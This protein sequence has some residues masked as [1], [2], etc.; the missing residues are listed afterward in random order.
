MPSRV[1]ILLVA[2]ASIFWVTA[3]S[4]IRNAAAQPPTETRQILGDWELSNDEYID[5]TKTK[6]IKAA[7]RAPA[8]KWGIS[9]D[10][11]T[12][13]GKVVLTYRLD[14]SESPKAID[15]VGLDPQNAHQ[16]TRGIIEVDGNK[17]IVCLA[18]GGTKDRPANFSPMAPAVR[19]YEFARVL[20]KKE[21]S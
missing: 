4:Q 15:I 18:K 21:P 20:P 7:R 2:V 17:L 3:Q 9:A 1:L 14:R 12:V 6:W 11:I 16:V 13:D 10:K 19:R 8:W 5:G